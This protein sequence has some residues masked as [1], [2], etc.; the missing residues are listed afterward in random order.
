MA[1]RFSM[2]L[3][4]LVGLLA[5][6]SCGSS[7]KVNYMYSFS[8]TGVC[9]TG[10]MTFTSLQ[11]MCTALQSDSVNMNCQLAKRMEWFTQEHCSGNFTEVP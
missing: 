3:A 5:A 11:A 7:G 1:L 6:A 8:E 4:G 2:G 9:D 10:E